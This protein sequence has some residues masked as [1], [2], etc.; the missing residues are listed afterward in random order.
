MLSAI[1]QLEYSFYIV[2][3][4]EKLLQK[5]FFLNVK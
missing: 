4:S 5:T 3:G 1:Q 2:D